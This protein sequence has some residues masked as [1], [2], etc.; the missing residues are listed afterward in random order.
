MIL[1]NVDGFVDA[2]CH[3]L[4]GVDD[5]AKDLETSLGFLR[6]AAAAGTSTIIATPHQ[7]PGRYPNR[8]TTLADAH[9]R[10]LEAIAAVREQ[11]ETLPDV[12]LGAEVHLDAG[13]PA[14]IEAGERLRL[15]GGPYLLLELPEVFPL[16]QVEELVYELQLACVLPVLAHPERIPQF[17]RQPDQLRRLVDRGALG[18]VTGSSV[19]GVFGAPCR[20][21]TFRFLR[22]GLV[23][24]VASDAHDL[25]RR[26]PSLSDAEAALT[27]ELGAEA[28]RS[29]LIDV[30]RAILEGD[31]IP[32]MPRMT[33]AA[34]PSKP[35]SGWRR[36]LPGT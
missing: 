1:K 14:L 33:P 24:L 17:L 20:E 26:T 2:H 25:T 29:L 3:V 21:I 9:A 30:P 34:E 18:Q 12:K 8:A 7:H 19:S 32:S 35:R 31:V 23:H 10:L 5:G 27:A 22:E 36:W 15:A 6:A 13:L 4:P 11:G 28:A 16:A